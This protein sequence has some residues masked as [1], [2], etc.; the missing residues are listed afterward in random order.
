MTAFTTEYPKIQKKPDT[1]LECE[2]VKNYGQWIAAEKKRAQTKRHKAEISYRRTKCSRYRREADIAYYMETALEAAER[3][4][5]GVDTAGIMVQRHMLGVYN[6]ASELV[7]VAPPEEAVQK[8]LEEIHVGQFRLYAK[9]KK[10]GDGVNEY[11][12]CG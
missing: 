1:D 4:L 6:W 3:E 7:K 2:S 10:K 9:I 12:D 8:I 11:R 5:S